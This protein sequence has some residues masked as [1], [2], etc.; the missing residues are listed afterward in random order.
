VS[1]EELESIYDDQQ[2]I[3]ALSGLAMDPTPKSPFRP[4]IDRIDSTRGYVSG[5]VQFVCS[6][7]NVMKNKLP[8]PEFIRLCRLIADHAHDVD[9]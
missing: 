4:S 5:N 3:C 6:V 8:E 9:S 7:V 2:G 1:T